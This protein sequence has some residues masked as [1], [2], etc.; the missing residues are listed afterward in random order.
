MNIETMEGRR[1]FSVTVSQPSPGFYELT[2]DAADDEITV[3]VD[4]A[5]QTFTYNGTEY[6][7]VDNITVL[8]GGGNDSISVYSVAAGPIG[9]SIDGGDGD[10]FISLNFSG[11]VWGGDGNDEIHLS[12]AFMGE[13]YG[14]GGNDTI[15]VA[16]NCID[17]LIDGGDGDDWID[18]TANNYGV[19]IQGGA[20][21]DQIY[22]S[23][24]SDQIDAGS[25]A[26]TIVA[27]GGNDQINTAGDGKVDWI[28]GGD[29]NDTLQADV[30]EVHVQNVERFV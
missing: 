22:G 29:G 28:D 2:G 5:N 18:A 11:G 21:D 10:D 14:Q 12:D 13:V 17:T 25:G 20:G 24:F 26:D 1:L 6:F 8:G 9:A 30:D 4:E 23:N 19:K 27:L 16:G 7:D 15:Y 3:A